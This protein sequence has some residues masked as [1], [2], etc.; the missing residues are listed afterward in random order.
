M[1][2]SSAGIGSGLDVASI[3]ASLMNVERLPLAA[4]AKQKTDYQSQ[5]SAYGTMKST[6]STFQTAVQALSSPAKFNAQTVTSGN[7][8][9]FT[10]TANVTIDNKLLLG[11]LL[12]MSNPDNRDHHILKEFKELATRTKSPSS[13]KSTNS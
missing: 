5:V 6:L 4:V 13:K 2:I 10:A 8:A 9:V 12:F 7:S 3:V 1:P 11:F